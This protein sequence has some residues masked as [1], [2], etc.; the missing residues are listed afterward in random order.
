MSKH[1]KRG[2]QG[3][4]LLPLVAVAGTAYAQEAA[5]SVEDLDQR[6]K[7]LE[8]QLEIQKEESD[9]KA[10]D[11]A[12]VSANEKGFSI[13]SA[14]GDYEFKFRGLL[15]A[16]GRWFVDDKAPR[17]GD[18]FL[19]RRV[20]PTFELTLG[21]ALFFR[22][23]PNFGK[24]SPEVSDVY[25][26]W[27]IDPAFYARAGKF[28][29]PVVL[30]NL[31]ASSATVFNERGFPTELGPNRDIGLQFGGAFL[32]STTTYALGV[33]NG[34][35]DGRDGTQQSGSTNS[36]G[37]NR[38]EVAARLFT[39]PFKNSPGLFQGLGLGVGG[40]YGE[41]LGNGD[42]SQV[43]YR[44]PGQNTFFN[45]QTAVTYDGAETRISPQAYYYRNSFGLLAEYIV[46]KQ[47]VANAAAHEKLDNKAWQAVANYLL[48]GEDASY[49]GLTKPKNSITQ[50]G[51]GAW[52]LVARYGV[53][54]VDNDAFT[55]K[56]YADITKSASKATT[57]AAGANWYPINN[58]KIALTYSQTSFDGGATTGDRED[59][60]LLFTRFQVAF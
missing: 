5:P 52:E 28:K 13:K 35:P 56:T 7:V 12:T 55:N 36:S 58:L 8:R 50:G 37:D 16:D 6:I 22:I 54:D 60:K 48:T 44:T 31:Q 40:S 47:E 11:S 19:M 25:G 18:G 14:K 42:S 24:D 46:A 43:K 29:A 45:Y 57:W 51:V 20:E 41:K 17:T 3:L 32:S 26:E 39:E 34:A 38:K 59:E 4:A 10:K 53:L 30:E 49:T 27:R 9:A 1:L 15:Q 21:K 33:F 23:Q 2:F